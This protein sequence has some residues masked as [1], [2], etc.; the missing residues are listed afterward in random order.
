MEWRRIKKFPNYEVSEFGDVR[1]CV[2]GV[3]RKK[4]YV[5]KGSIN[6]DGYRAYT[7]DTKH[8]ALAHRLVAMEFLPTPHPGMDQVAH[9]DGS[10]TNNHFSNLRWTD[11]AGN[12]ADAARHGTRKGSRNGRSKLTEAD[13]RRCIILH[14]SGTRVC[15]LAR[16]YNVSWTAMSYA[17]TG[18]NWG[19]THA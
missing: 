9:G 15:D 11:T 13:V 6:Q 8:H 18:E 7:L 10:K 17:L 19:H 4:G 5:L 12:Q 1:R 14:K 2:D 3:T 16:R